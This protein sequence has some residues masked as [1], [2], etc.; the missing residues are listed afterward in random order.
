MRVTR[1][2]CIIAT[3]ILLLCCLA[4]TSCPPIVVSTLP[5]EPLSATAADVSRFNGKTIF[6]MV[7]GQPAAKPESNSGPSTLYNYVLDIT[8]SG[9]PSLA[10]SVVADSTLNDGLFTPRGSSI[11]GQKQVEMDNK[12]RASENQALASRAVQLNRKG[13]DKAAPYPISVGTT[14]NSVYI[15][16]SGNSI[17][18]TCQ[19]ISTY[20]Y[21][22]VDNRD[23]AAMAS[24]LAGYGTAF[25]AIYGVNHTHF[26]SENDTD[27]NGKLIIVF[28]EEL[29]GG[30]L[31]YFYAVDKYPKATYAE[32]NEGDIFYITTTGAYQ[33]SIVNGTLAHEFQHMIYFDEHYNRS[34]TST[35]SWLNEALSQASEYY[36]GYTDNH[37]AWVADYLDGGWPGLSLTH[38]TSSNYGYGAVY[39]RYL[40]D[41]FGDTAITNMCATSLVGIA[42]V[43]AATGTDFNTLFN[44][45]TRALVMSGTGDSSDPIYNFTTLD[46]QTV[47]PNGRGG[48]TTSS[49]Y[50]IPNSVSGGLYPYRLSFINWTGTVGTM[51]LTGTDVN[52]TGFG[53]SQ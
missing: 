7:T 35:Y 43:E 12:A 3:A 41:R 39:I 9:S 49:S 26:G 11:Y 33:G 17:N 20:A 15:A 14:W 4:L 24:Y 21:F 50:S 51:T 6:T 29:S 28:S 47:Q 13:I 38:W 5:Y 19:Y 22:F 18:T 23:T 34:V 42:A 48:L 36:N 53:L 37:L 32:S 45:F 8:A 1:N 46:L 30:L 27:S 52:G 44:E 2:T 25:D 40:R 16:T 10:P 31:G